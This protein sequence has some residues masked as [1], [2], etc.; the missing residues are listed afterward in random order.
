M[1]NRFHVT[2]FAIVTLFLCFAFHS[3][4]SCADQ[5][6]ILWITAEDMS[7]TLGCYGDDYATTPNIDRLA[8]QS[9][10]YTH[11][12]A[13][14]PVCSPSRACL[15]NG[16]I[17]T[18]QGAHSMR[19]LFPLPAEMKGFPAILRKQGY[20]TT[21][22]VKTDYNSAA[23]TSITAAAWD[24][25][26][27]TAHWR[28]RK[29]GQPF[30]SVFN[31]MTSHQSRTMVWPYQ[32][33]QEEVQS[34]L[35]K[36]LIH[37]P[38][39]APL[40]PYYPDTPLVRK[41]VARYYDCVTV[42]DQQVGEILSQ[43]ESDG[44]AA[45]TIVFFYSDHGSGMPRHKRALFDSGMHV[46]MLIRFP[47]K[48][49]TLAPSAAGATVKRLV[50]FEDFGP[51]VLSLAG[52]DSLPRY[53]RG[54]PFLGPL[55][56]PPRKLLF[57]HRDRV[58]EII[59]MARSVRSKDFL[60]IRNF[61]PHLGYNQQSAWIDQGEIRQDFY[62]L[63][64]SGGATPAQ[65]QYLN[66]TRPREELYDCQRDP[67]NL[68]NLAGSAAH[69]SILA[70]MRDALRRH[71][72]ESHDLGFV[73]EIELWRVSSGTTP[74]EWASTDSLDIESLYRAAELVGTE[75]FAAIRSALDDQDASMQYWGAVSCSAAEK[76]PDAMTQRLVDALDAESPAVRIEAANAIAR[77]TNNPIARDTL[78]G[79]LE[80]SDQ[81]VILHAARA[82]ELLGDPS[83]HE[84]M[85][86]LAD[87]FEDE[88]GDIAWFIRFS[89]SGYLSRV[90]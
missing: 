52:T 43:L 73:P 16:C 76:L 48:Y 87:R 64:R 67:Q 25:S 88:P 84:P 53:M 49:Q 20:Y 86:R 85:Q 82:I 70:S 90:K 28:S 50:N 44:L 75:D 36:D 30:F 10:R 77:H 78:V 57:G 6:N 9:S 18:T 13:T 8:T 27:E 35:S 40:P 41:T 81:T 46:P 24:D 33:F 29:P 19:S 37:D 39:R 1:R 60:Y 26:R 2:H 79:L 31:L 15:I 21:N 45:D 38:N 3:K 68:N 71:I 51:T 23:A 12:F 34:K 55:N 59:D 74:I 65:A 7:A 5:P 32:Q 63:A 47:E 56:T 42:M 69:Q 89:T 80:H 54:R 66:A 61:M 83:M 17:A 62:A 11:A 14:A 58:D 72:I 22:N 4:A